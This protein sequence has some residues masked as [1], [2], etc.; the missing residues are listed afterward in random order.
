M[1]T[2]QLHHISELSDLLASGCYWA[3]GKNSRVDHLH[4]TGAQAALAKENIY[5]IYLANEEYAWMAFWM[6][7]TDRSV[8]RK[9]NLLY[10]RP[11]GDSRLGRLQIP[12]QQNWSCHQAYLYLFASRDFADLPVI[13]LRQV[14]HDERELEQRGFS[15]QSILRHGETQRN[16]C[17]ENE[18]PRLV[19]ID[20]W[21][22]SLINIPQVVP[23]IEV[24]LTPSLIE[25]A[26]RCVVFSDEPIVGHY[27]R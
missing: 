25:E 2:V 27:L 26:S 18:A 23:S 16:Y 20:E 12:P 17:Y 9:R 22:V 15:L 4:R 19:L 7:I 24:V 5:G 13:D 21:Q 6:A 8:L 14:R 3:N 1:T 10:F 11:S